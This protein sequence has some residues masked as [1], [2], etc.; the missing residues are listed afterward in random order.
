M[1]QNGAVMGHPNHAMSCQ[2]YVQAVEKTP[3]P[4]KNV[5][6]VSFNPNHNLSPNAGKVHF[7]HKGLTSEPLRSQLGIYNSTGSLIQKIIKMN[8]FESSNC[9]IS[10]RVTA[11]C[12]PLR[13]SSCP[14]G[15]QVPLVVP[16]TGGQSSVVTFRFIEKA[17]VKTLNGFPLIES[18]KENGL[19]RSLESEED[20]HFESNKQRS[21]KTNVQTQYSLQHKVT[22]SLNPVILDNRMSFNVQTGTSSSAITDE[23]DSVV[24][25]SKQEH[26]GFKPKPEISASD[27]LLAGNRFLLNAQ[28]SLSWGNGTPLSPGASCPPSSL[29]GEMSNLS[30]DLLCHRRHPQSKEPQYQ[31]SL[32]GYSHESSAH[33]QRVAKAKWEFF[34]GSMESPKTGMPSQNALDPSPQ[35]PEKSKLSVQQKPDQI[36]PEHSLCHVEVEI[37][38]TP[39][40]N[41]KF[42]NCETGIIRR[43][44]KYSETD[45]D[46]VPLR[47]Y[48][49]TNIDDILAEREEVD[50]AIESQKDSESNFSSVGIPKKANIVPN[51]LFFQHAMEE[52][53]KTLDNK[54][55]GNKDGEISEAMVHHQ[56]RVINR[57][58][59]LLK[60]PVPFL[61]GQNIPK[62]SMDSFS[63]HF[64]SI[65]ESHRAKGTSYTSLDSIDILSSPTHTQNGIVFTFDLPT[66]TPEIQEEI[67]DSAKIIEQNFAPLAFLEPDSGTSSATDVPWAEREEEAR[68]KWKSSLQSPC[69]SEGSLGIPLASI[70]SKH[71]LSQLVSDS[72]SEMD[73]TEQLAL[74][75]TDTL[76]SGHNADLEAAKRLAKRLYNLDG[77][78]KADVARHLGK[79]ND[80]SKTV[81]GEYLKFFE[82]TG[83]TLDQALRSF[84]KEL[85]LVGETQ[86]R[87]RILA[88]FS[89]RFY[90]CNPKTIPSEDGAH[91]LACA[92]MLLNTD[93]HGHNIGKRMSCSDFIGNLEGLNQGSDF[94]RE[95]LKA[96]YNSIKNEKLQWAID[97]EELR[98]SLSELAD[99]NSKSI[100][101][102]SSCSNPF[103]DFS[104]DPSIAMYKHGLLVRKSHAEPDC[105]KTPR[106]KRGWKT[107]HGIL[108]GMILY[109]QKEEYKPGQ[110]L[111]EE[112]LKNAI[113]IHHSLATQASDYSKRPN[114]FYLRTADWRVFLF[115]A[116]NTEQMH[117]WITRINVVAAMFSAPPF[118]AAIGSQKKF[119]R[120]LLPSSSTRLS[121]EEQ[122]KSHEMK[123]K[124]MV[125]E[126]LEHRSSLPE[127]KVKGKEYEELK[128]KEE[129]LIFEKLR[130]GIYATLMRTKLKTG[131]EDLAALEATLFVTVGNS[132]DSFKESQSSLALNPETAGTGSKI[133]CN[134]Q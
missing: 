107:F 113:S 133:K 118:P 21:Q 38:M 87:E 110:S 36:R 123:F 102:I 128:Q 70:I 30:N 132:E 109:L 40:G 2:H 130:Y 3:P 55:Q 51:D 134:N 97:E 26:L 42:E 1:A 88:H 120:P 31:G 81:A 71:H 91:T 89:Q 24:L 48:H 39:P 45:L 57:K 46:T 63:K 121:Q 68:Q 22:A 13:S 79:N 100:K 11:P 115:Q 65:M 82:F 112:D 69:H 56:E 119:I 80:F 61:F 47:C 52:D 95:L 18:R 67:Q 44:V 129:Y 78:K 125:A 6:P 8:N 90:E 83:M 101:C 77:F 74:G 27:P 12:T 73:S 17:N 59:Q 99:S 111:A 98:K 106:G 96:V 43:T 126:L 34:Y 33:A 62:D 131:S 15:N 92:L 85:A 49:E 93:L 53:S 122:L 5:I 105:K 16:V 127:K 58:S 86:E 116:Q 4:S 84:L 76:S 35:L 14:S 20:F 28:P 23:Q 7:L 72:D 94:P 25:S 37:E 9:P 10:G 103:L 32:W 108:K 41:T 75:S 117:S 104:Q 19:S 114:V 66:L 50:S 60:S 29:I 54:N 124:A 64:E